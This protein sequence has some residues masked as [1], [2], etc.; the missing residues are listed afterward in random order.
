METQPIAGDLLVDIPKR[1]RHDAR[2]ALCEVR[3]VNTVYT[4]PQ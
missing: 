3:F 2:E 4:P 1:D